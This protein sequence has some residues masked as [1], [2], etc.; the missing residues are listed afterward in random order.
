MTDFKAQTYLENI[1][2]NNQKYNLLVKGTNLQINV[3]K[4][5]LNLPNGA[6]TTY[7]DVANFVNSLK[8][9]E[10]LRVPSEKSHRLSHSV[11]SCYC[12]KWCDERVQLG[13]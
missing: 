10:L 1:F 4:A 8:P 9:C 13:H 5:L 2:I 12:Q 7:Q 6:V 3:W 11:S